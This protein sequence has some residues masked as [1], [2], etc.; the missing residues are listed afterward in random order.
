MLQGPASSVEVEKQHANIQCD[1]E[2]KKSGAKRAHTIQK[3]SY[4]MS[5]CLEHSST[6]AAVLSEALGASKTKVA[7]VFRNARL[8]D[9]SAPSALQPTRF[10][11]DEQGHVKGRTGLLKGMLQLV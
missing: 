7:R 5:C 1:I 6:R 9:S 3:D 4:I 11:M 10:K 8:L 2:S